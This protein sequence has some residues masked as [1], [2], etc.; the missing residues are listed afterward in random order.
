ML[1]RI[2][3]WVAQFANCEGFKTLAFQKSRVN[4]RKGILVTKCELK[5]RCVFKH[6]NYIIQR[7]FSCWSVPSLLSWMDWW[8]LQQGVNLEDLGTCYTCCFEMPNEQDLVQEKTHT[9]STCVTYD[10]I[11]FNSN[12][13]QFLPGSIHHLKYYSLPRG[14]ILNDKFQPFIHLH[15]NHSSYVKPVSFSWELWELYNPPNRW[16]PEAR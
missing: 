8:K 5:T 7:R 11:I 15:P 6:W 4:N 10:N 3:L 9:C 1:S 16:L 14:W 13:P 2:S 12:T